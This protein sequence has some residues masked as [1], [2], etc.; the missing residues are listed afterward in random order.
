M[1]ISNANK[2]QILASVSD[3]DAVHALLDIFDTMAEII[4]T[5]DIMSKN[6]T[7]AR[8]DLALAQDENAALRQRIAE[9]EAAIR[10]GI[11]APNN[12]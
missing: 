11:E 2:G 4:E 8:A 7:E 9:L 5:G 12:D 1:Y 3:P 6:L 10:F